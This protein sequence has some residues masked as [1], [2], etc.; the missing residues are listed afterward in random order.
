MK[1]IA[2]FFILSIIFLACSK[3]KHLDSLEHDVPVVKIEINEKHLWSADSGLYIIGSNGTQRGT[4]SGIANY[5]QDWEYPAFFSLQIDDEEVIERQQLGFKIKG[6][7][8]R[9]NAMKSIG[10]YWRKEYGEKNI[11]YPFFGEESADTYKRLFLRNSGNDFGKTHIKD[12]VI[13]QIIRDHTTA[14]TQ[15]YTPCAVYL[16]EEYW[17]IH[18][19]RDMLTPHHFKYKYDAEK[20]YVDI[21]EGDEENPAVDDGTSTLFMSEVIDFVNQNNMELDA[22]IG[23]IKDRINIE[24]YMDYIITQTYIANGDQLTNNVKWWRDATSLTHNKWTWI[25]YDTDLSFSLN[26]VNDLW[27]GNLKGEYKSGFFLFN[28]L[29]QNKQFKNDFLNRYLYFI[30]TVFEP[31]R[32][33]DIIQEIAGGIESEY[34]NHRMKWDL[35]SNYSWNLKINEL[36]KFNTTRNKFMREEIIKL[37]NNVR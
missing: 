31:E 11:E 17:G 15:D 18:N 9:A 2:S 37:I 4:C 16:N 33:E 5:N 24:S 8:T 23:I 19:M 3:E 26:N 1:K 30:D 13:T 35:P 21:L 29:I 7:C 12:A 27:I 36:V 25:V 6:N 34:N 22:N 14:E 32:V 20:S 10:L 28:K